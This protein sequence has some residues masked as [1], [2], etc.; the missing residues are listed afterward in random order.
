MKRYIVN[1]IVYS[2]GILFFVSLLIFFLVRILPG[3]PIQVAAMQNMDLLNTEVME[4]L[5][6][7]MGLNVPVH[8]QY[9][10]WVTNFFKGEWGTSF[11]TGEK[12]SEMFLRRLS[13]TL[14]LFV[15][16]VLWSFVIGFPLG[17]LSA[18]K[19]NTWFDAMLTTTAVFG[20]SIPI[21][22]EAILLIYIFAVKWQVLP[23]SGFVPFSESP[24][25]NLLS[26]VMPSFVMGTHSAGLITRYVRSSLLEV[27]GQDYIRT[28]RAKGLRELQIL[29]R[30]ASRLSMIPVVTVLGLSWGYI[31]AG[32]FIVEY[33]FAI[34]GLGRMGVEAVFARDFPVIQ[35]TLV[36]VAANIL[37]MNLIV[38]IIYGYLDPRVSLYGTR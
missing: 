3:D 16:S 11:G 14:E 24:W 36:I 25:Q 19:R 34:P 7:Q 35:S 33:M 32:S 8:E 26:I 18:L 10:A 29:V 2:I 22:W 31:V 5:R 20:V 6:E 21:F 23:P 12:V 30:H 15:G 27:L 9:A 38:D 28:A 37:V 13:P 4:D 17:V 1:R